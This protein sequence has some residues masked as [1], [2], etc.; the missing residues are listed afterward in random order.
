MEGGVI[1]DGGRFY[2]ALDDELLYGY[3]EAQDV[4]SRILGKRKFSELSVQDQRLLAREFSKR[5]PVK[6]PENAK[7]KVQSKPAGYEQI[8]YNWRDTNY[9]HEIRWHTRTPGAPVDQGNTWVVLRTT[10]GTGGTTKAV[11]N[12]LLNDRTWVTGKEWSDAITAR[13]YG[14][15]TLREIE[16]LDRGHWSD[17]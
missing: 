3:N 14:M 5:S 9:K 1:G 6:I 7:I 10:P 17:Y 2:T 15:P 13:K 8:S 4:Y 16:I 11:D 12:Y